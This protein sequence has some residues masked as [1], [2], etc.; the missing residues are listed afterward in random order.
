MLFNGDGHAR[1]E[2]RGFYTLQRGEVVLGKQG[3]PW[4]LTRE[5]ALRRTR[6]PFIAILWKPLTP[7]TPASK[8]TGCCANLYFSGKCKTCKPWA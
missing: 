8:H 3:K 7:L 6:T 5:E 4:F 2:I 1:G